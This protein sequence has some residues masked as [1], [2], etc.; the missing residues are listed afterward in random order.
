MTLITV[1]SYDDIDMSG[2]RLNSPAQVNRSIWT[3]GRKVIGMPGGESW[4]GHRGRVRRCAGVMSSGGI[5][6]AKLLAIWAISA[7]MS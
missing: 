1:P 3:G 6:A 7:S 4:T 2:P 5:R